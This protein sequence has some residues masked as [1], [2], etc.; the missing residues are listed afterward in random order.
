MLW[1][2]EQLHHLLANYGLWGLALIIGLESIGLPLPGE[3]ALIVASV[4]VGTHHHSV[5]MVIIAAAAGAIVGDN[6]GYWLGHRFGFN[7]LHRYGARFGATENRVKLGQYLFRLHGAKVVFFGRFIA[8]LRVLAAFLAG[9][10]RLPWPTFFLANVA[11]AI[12]WASSVGLA[13]STFGESFLIVS[14]PVAVVLLLIATIVVVAATIYLRRNEAT[15]LDKAERAIP[16]SVDQAD[17]LG[18]GP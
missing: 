4:Y 2:E 6:I 3:A 8:V 17:R 9:V 14:R 15:L 7:F 18:S 11:G 10:N 16:E 1:H 5:T 12:V 13:A